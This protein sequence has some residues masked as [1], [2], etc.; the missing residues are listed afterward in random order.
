[1]KKLILFVLLF[2][3]QIIFSQDY[4]LL[5]DSII[6][7]YRVNPKA[8]DPTF[9]VETITKTNAGY[10]QIEKWTF[11]DMVVVNTALFEVKKDGVYQ[12]ASGGGL[13]KSPVETHTYPHP[14]VKYPVKKNNEWSYLQDNGVNI[15]RKIIDVLTNFEVKGTVYSDVILIKQTTNDGGHILIVFEYYAKDIGLILVET[16]DKQVFK[17]LVSSD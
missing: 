7:T 3:T 4:F 5:K 10:T 13:L 9:I 17:F 12:V 2:S 11:G 14:I 6:K 16:E 15:H 1:M 8:K